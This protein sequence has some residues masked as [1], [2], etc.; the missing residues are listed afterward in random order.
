MFFNRKSKKE[1]NN[2]YAIYIESENYN[3]IVQNDLSLINFLILYNDNTA[4]SIMVL[5]GK[6]N[7]TQGNFIV[8]N[9]HI[10]LKL[11]RGHNKEGFTISM[12]HLLTINQN[13]SLHTDIIYNNI[14]SCNN[15]ISQN[16][17]LVE[18]KED[19]YN[20][21]DTDLLT[22]TEAANQKDINYNLLEYND[23]KKIRD[24]IN[25]AYN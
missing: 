9:K 4:Q 10:I 2:I 1:N 7:I 25:K 11:D 13:N 16:K 15:S 14:K 5:N 6:E 3:K 24:K 19:I 17:S 8:D 18:L 12:Y 22:K 23:Y 21:I 20:G